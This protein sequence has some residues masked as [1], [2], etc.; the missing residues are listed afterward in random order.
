MTPLYVTRVPS[1]YSLHQLDD[2]FPGKGLVPTPH[3]PVSDIPGQ[4]LPKLSYSPA[5]GTTSKRVRSFGNLQAHL[6]PDVDEPSTLFSGSDTDSVGDAQVPFVQDSPSAGG[7]NLMDSI[8]LAEWEDRAEQ[9]LFRYDVTACPTQLVPGTYGFIAQC[10]EGRASKK[11]ATE[12]RVDQVCQPWDAKKFNF[13]KALQQEILFQ[14]E[15]GLQGD[16]NQPKFIPASPANTSPNLVFINVSPIEYGHVLL[17]PHVMDDLTQLVDQQSMR[18]AL[19]FCEHS[20][21][22]YF[23]LCYNSLGAYGTIN[24]L[25]F[26]GYYLQAP[27]AVE[28]APTAPVPA[29]S[30][31]RRFKDV[32]VYQLVEYPVRGLVFECGQN[33]PDMA[34]FVAEVCV[35]LQ[36]AN[37]PHNLFIV[38]CGMRVF[39]YPNAFA[40]A[41]A[42]GRVPSELLDSQVDP[43]SFEISGHIIM[44]RQQDY[45]GLTQEAVWDLLS[46]ASLSEE[47]FIKFSHFALDY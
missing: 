1:V 32:R 31:S 38:D 41:K 43:A 25:H 15:A 12:F 28:R 6:V 45:D 19:Q 21:N 22:P 11:R 14:Y 39:L 20:S 35:R 17:V 23:R 27:F 42:E 18:L 46:Y 3:S 13:Q 2:G 24:H 44:K 4:L 34:D 29:Y 33:L 37:I 7:S 30:G 40:A 9:G 36:E 10:N 47:A 16:G 5:A 26:Q 8:L